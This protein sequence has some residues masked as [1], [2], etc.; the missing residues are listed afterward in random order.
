LLEASAKTGNANALEDLGEL[1]L[2]GEDVA[3]HPVKARGYLERAIRGGHI[4]A[5]ILLGVALIKG[6]GV[7]KDITEGERLLRTAAAKDPWA[8]L[9]L[10]SMLLSGE[11]P[12]DVP[13][14]LTL[15]EASAESGNRYALEKL[16]EMYL[17]GKDVVADLEKGR[18][19]L[20]RAAAMKRQ[21]SSQ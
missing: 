17:E 16:G 18:I 4:R 8:Q 2:K 6:S 19:Y 11:L 21:T 12:R 3:A 5:Q 13:R 7:P 10:G 20:K 14:A 1:Y 9:A 15:L